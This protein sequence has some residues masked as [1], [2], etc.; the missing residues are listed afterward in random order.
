MFN[1]KVSDHKA[2]K[3]CSIISYD[4]KHKII[5]KRLTSLRND[6]ITKHSSYIGNFVIVFLITQLIE[7]VFFTKTAL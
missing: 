4:C 2:T 6:N 7:A 1:F 5:L 3:S